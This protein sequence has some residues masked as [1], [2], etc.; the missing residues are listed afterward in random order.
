MQ[1]VNAHNHA[2]MSNKLLDLGPQASSDSTQVGH[3]YS[4]AP[5]QKESVCG[6]TNSM[7]NEDSKKGQLVQE[8]E[9]EK[10]KVGFQVYGR[11][12]TMAYKGTLVPFII[13]SLIFFE[14]LE[15]CGNYWMALEVPIS[16]DT[17]PPVSGSTL[18]SVYVALAVGSS[19]CNL[20]RT[21]LTM[22][23]GLKTAT[24]LFNSMHT[25]IFRAPI[26]FFD[27]TPTGRILSRV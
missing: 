20:V 13:L 5:K 24:L 27:S 10:G 18:I 1:L 11:Y 26:S 6:E 8:E 19:A 25:C 23:A 2:L 12:I 7:S 9:R 21:M 15:I 16:D 4:M 3:S 14:V 17:E 22:T